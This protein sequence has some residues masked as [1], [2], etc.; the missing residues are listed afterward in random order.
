M[1][2]FVL[3]TAPHGILHSIQRRASQP[4]CAIRL[5]YPALFVE[6][7]NPHLSQ[8]YSP[9]SPPMQRRSSPLEDIARSASIAIHILAGACWVVEYEEGKLCFYPLL[10]L[11]RVSHF[12]KNLHQ[13]GV[14]LEQ[15]LTY[16][17]FRPPYN[18]WCAAG[19]AGAAT[20]NVCLHQGTEPG[21]VHSFDA[22]TNRVHDHLSFLNG[23][24]PNSRQT[25]IISGAV[26][27]FYGVN[28]VTRKKP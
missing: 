16:R 21:C 1:K 20:G 27:F 14:T 5:R 18:A 6:D 15:V 19:Q 11:T 13:L 7:G 22:P 12:N 28:G 24:S 8:G 9:H 17:H 3:L 2:N 4:P 25:A 23:L 26:F 10:K